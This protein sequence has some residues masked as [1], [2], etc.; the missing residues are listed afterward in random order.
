MK[1]TKRENKYLKFNQNETTRKTPTQHQQNHSF[2]VYN[3]HHLPNR[4]NFSSL[5]NT[6]RIILISHRLLAKSRTR[7]AQKANGKR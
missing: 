2:A 7:T 6:H 5:G 3:L 1:N 4:P